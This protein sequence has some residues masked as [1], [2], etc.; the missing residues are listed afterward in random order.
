MKG[1]LWGKRKAREEAEDPQIIFNSAMIQ[2]SY[3]ETHA[4]PEFQR[5][6]NR[7]HQKS[8]WINEILKK[9]NL[10]NNRNVAK[11]FVKTET[12]IG[13]FIAA[14][15]LFDNNNQKSDEYL[16]R[17]RELGCVWAIVKYSRYIYD[18]QDQF[19]DIVDHHINVI[20]NAAEENNPEA[21]LAYANYLGFKRSKRAL[22]YAIKSYNLGNKY[23][24]RLITTMLAVTG[25]DYLSKAIFYTSKYENTIFTA[26]LHHIFSKKNLM[27]PNCTSLPLQIGRTMYWQFYQS[28]QL[29]YLTRGEIIEFGEK[30]MDYYC[31][32]MDLQQ[33]SIFSFLLSWNYVTGGMK[34][35]GKLIAKMV[36]DV[37]YENAIKKFDS[38]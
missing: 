25:P 12:A 35:V 30:C 17:S 21:C 3:N 34:D 24:I 31:E 2:L 36:W 6:A 26:M 29:N 14:E 18:N 5:A 32:M 13:Y 33:Q 27:D 8:I 7:G 19:L 37:R 9:S 4:Y 15:V 28:K 11:N 23:A 20:K 38:F 22:E 16:Q 1:L 10:Y